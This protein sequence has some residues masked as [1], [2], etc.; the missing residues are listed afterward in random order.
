[1]LRRIRL[2]SKTVLVGGF[3]AVSLAVTGAALAAPGGPL[4]PTG[5]A[6]TAA[7]PTDKPSEDPGK[8]AKPAK[9]ET[10]DADE[11]SDAPKTTSASHPA[12]DRSCPWPTPVALPTPHD[13]GLHCGWYKPGHSAPRPHPAQAHGPQSAKTHGHGAD[14]ADDST[15]DSTHD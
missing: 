5:D 1:M 8:S 11:P 3:A 6:T 4:A 14:G 15:H 9:A 2:A 12:Q 10:P 13:Q 7:T